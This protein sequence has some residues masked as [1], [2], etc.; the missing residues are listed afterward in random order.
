MIVPAII[1]AAI[2]GT[3]YATR[4]RVSKTPATELIKGR[5]YRIGVNYNANLAPLSQGS[6][7]TQLEYIRTQIFEQALPELGFKD[8]AYVSGPTGPVNGIYTYWYEGTYTLDER[9]FPN[10][11]VHPYLNLGFYEIT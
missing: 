1:T 2:L 4:D 9:T 10:R 11:T 3:L 6:P 7:A 5:R 8:N